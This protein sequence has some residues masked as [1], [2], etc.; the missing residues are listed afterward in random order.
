MTQITVK[1][2]ILFVKETQVTLETVIILILI[3]QQQEFILCIVF[4]EGQTCFVRYSS[5]SPILILKYFLT[6][7]RFYQA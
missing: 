1:K 7:L 3:Y 4:G 6:Y 5:A 2:L